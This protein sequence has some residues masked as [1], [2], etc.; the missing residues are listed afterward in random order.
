MLL[1]APTSRL[2]QPI[3]FSL[4][5]IGHIFAV[6]Y[7]LHNKHLHAPEPEARSLEMRIVADLPRNS[8]QPTPLPLN[9][10]A[11]ATDVVMPEIEI[12]PHD[13]YKA[14]A[15]QMI[16]SLA[17]QI[18][19][20]IIATTGPRPIPE[21]PNAFPLAAYPAAA[22]SAGQE[23]AVTLSL[24]VS[25]RGDIDDVMI[26]KSSGYA[27]LDQTAARHA[28]RHWRFQPGTRNGRPVADWKR[29]VVAFHLEQIEVIYR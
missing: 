19:E 24:Q 1:A 8:E 3:A 2:R 18:D 25:V 4:A 22:K 14:P 13:A 29:V 28:Q 27:A 23:G 12:A 6:D 17:P 7:L 10:E 20:P 21:A 11:P 16:D 9:L 26:E 15:L 5:L